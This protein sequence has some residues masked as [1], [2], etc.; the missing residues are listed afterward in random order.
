LGIFR[1]K[2][3]FGHFCSCQNLKGNIAQLPGYSPTHL[4][5][6]CSLVNT[7]PLQ[8]GTKMQTEG[9]RKPTEV[10]KSNGSEK[11][12]TEVKKS[13]R[14]EIKQMGVRSCKRMLNGNF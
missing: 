12:R 1:S 8:G 14:S 4:S 6:F 13:N 11:N 9:K 3:L 7:V 5:T 2:F 10:K